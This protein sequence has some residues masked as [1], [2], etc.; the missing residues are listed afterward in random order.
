MS[1]T[2]P[3][4]CMDENRILADTQ[5]W[6]DV[7]VIGL[8]LCPFA[9]RSIDSGRLRIQISA[10]AEPAEL[11]DLLVTELGIL[12]SSGS[13]ESGPDTLDSS[14]LVL[15]NAL[16][17]FLDFN[18]F[19]EAANATL[20]GESLEGEI[21]IATFHPDYRFEATEPNAIGNYT[22]RSPYP[23]LHLIREEAVS[24]A[25]A[26]HPDP[27]GIPARNI[28]RLESLGEDA[29]RKLLAR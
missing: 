3:A 23:M 15:P 13:T 9:Q 27:E 26:V 21:Q 8:E 25:I 20:V 6:I 5:H 24:R 17:D 11:L 29:L 2:Q 4:E 12:K 18:D 28:A 16:R 14:L 22:N 7:V 10:A 19:L 1:E